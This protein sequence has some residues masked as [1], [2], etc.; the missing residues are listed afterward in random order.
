MFYKRILEY[1]FL[2]ILG[3]SLYYSIE[4]IFRGY[5][6]YSMFILGGL[7][8]VFFA[9]QG[10]A[11]KWRD[12]LWIQLLRCTIFIACGE[13][14]TGIIVNKW[15]KWN[16]WD[17]KELPFQLFGQICLPFTLL[18]SGLSLIGIF[19]CGYILHWIFHEEKPKYRLL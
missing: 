2:W 15:L 14:I 8:M 12:P 18:F 17:Y 4:K 13:F 3:G 19:L 5:S 16:V 6:H 10:M 7:C 9:F 1:T 11:V